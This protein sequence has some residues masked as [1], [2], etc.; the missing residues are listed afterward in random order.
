MQGDMNRICNAFLMEDS[1]SAYDHIQ[2]ELITDYGSKAYG[3]NLY[4]WD[5]GE[6]WLGKCRCGGYVL[7]Q[8][9][10][11]HG[12]DGEDCEYTDYFPVSG[13]KHADKL[14]RDYNGFD[15]ERKFPARYLLVTDDT[16]H[17]SEERKQDL[18]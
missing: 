14:N 5:E 7:V 11:Y 9:S 16:I 10:E 12:A 4:V 13:P 18:T 15:I 1:K 2:L 17:W 8:Y 6:R 3:H